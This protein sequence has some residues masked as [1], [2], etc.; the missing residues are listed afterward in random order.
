MLVWK[1]YWGGREVYI[2]RTHTVYD[3]FSVYGGRVAVSGVM[4]SDS[5]PRKETNLS[6]E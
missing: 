4:A 1:V 6:S 2:Y 5:K 3:R